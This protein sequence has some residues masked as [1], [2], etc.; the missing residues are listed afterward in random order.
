MPTSN[1]LDATL[2]HAIHRVTTALVPA[3]AVKASSLPD[4]VRGYFRAKGEA[5]AANPVD[6]LCLPPMELKGLES[7]MRDAERTSMTHEQQGTT[8]SERNRRLAQFRLL[9]WLETAQ[10]ASSKRLI[11]GS[12]DALISENLGQKKVRALELIVRSLIT[13]SY[14]DQDKLTKRLREALQ[15][16][17]AKRCLQQ[18]DPGDVLSGLS[19]S[20]LAT[21]FVNK[22]EFAR[23]E[24]IYEDTPFL[25]MLKERRKT[26]R[27]FLDDVRRIRNTLAHN[28]K[29]S[30]TQLSL[31]DLYYEEIIS[32]VQ[33]A[34]DQ[35]E[36]GVDPS[37]FLDV[38]DNV[39]KAYVDGLREDVQEVREDIA[40]FRSSVEGRLDGIASD[41]KQVA[42]RT[43]G[44]D[45]RM[46]AIAA[47]ILALLGA[48]YFLFLKGD[49]TKERADAARKASERTELTAHETRKTAEDARDAATAAADTSRETADR[50]EKAAADTRKEVADAA[51]AIKKTGADTVAAAQAAK[52]AAEATAE[53][54]RRV[55]ESL[56][57]LKSGYAALMSKG[58]VIAKADRPSAHY[59]NARVY[60]SRG[61]TANAMESYRKFF[62]FPDL[63]FVD[64]HLKYQSLLKVQQG[65]AGA[66][67]V[68]AAMKNASK[69]PVTE[70]AWTLLLP[71]EARVHALEDFA[72]KHTEFAPAH[73]E[74]SK[75]YS[76]ARMGSQTLWEKEREKKHLETFFKLRDE[77][78]FLKHYLDQSEAAKQIQDAQVRLR[79]ARSVPATV[80]ERP[81]SMTAI[82][83]SSGW[84][85]SFVVAEIA[86]E[87]LWRKGTSGPFKST[88][89]SNTPDVRTGKP[90]PNMTVTLPTAARKTALQ[91]KYVDA[92]GRERGPYEM[93]FDPK[94]RMLA[95]QKSALKSIKNSWVTFRDYDGK[96]ILYFTMLVSY[97]ASL[98]RIEYGIDADPNRDFPIPPLDPKYPQAVD[99]TKA[100]L[101]I[102][103][104][105]ETKFATVRL[106]YA[107]DTV[108]EISRFLR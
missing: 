3:M 100:T 62:S 94:A 82:H 88:G 43:K 2:V 76:A 30:P 27:F 90:Q 53:S 70:F 4:A 86:K 55:A 36:V 101:H 83:S 42:T 97:R 107:D 10:R 89:R 81:V 93:E 73:Y 108:S 6:A 41:A 5:D 49:E 77:T 92:R 20:D 69:N 34:H 75:E 74:L 44:M 9:S 87:I 7:A 17:V 57:D 106:T 68:Y 85:V 60:Q 40:E 22:E 103:V 39:L 37:N 47:G 56:D 84:M 19:F 95:F 33:S 65:P 59:H 102:Y 54:T 21:L 35:G 8:Q 61:E 45:R 29:I 24:S 13:E 48:S 72:A 16:K 67:E 18:A 98:K 15:S 51:D 63:G 12:V 52:N 105:K 104:P 99:P 78:A 1:S 11:D 32:P 80:L 66:R 46:W 25:T 79:A 31:M 14:G 58:G 23:Y 26:I 91:V 38:N 71:A 28:K 96:V 50:V 64:P